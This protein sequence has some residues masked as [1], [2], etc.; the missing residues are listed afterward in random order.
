MRLLTDVAT[1]VKES[2]LRLVA[3]VGGKLPRTI[4]VAA[5]KLQAMSS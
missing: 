2:A 1:N 4:S 5:Q 3:T